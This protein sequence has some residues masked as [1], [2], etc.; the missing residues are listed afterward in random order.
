LL[1]VGFCFDLLDPANVNNLR[2]Y[3]QSFDRTLKESPTSSLSNVRANKKLNCAVFNFAH[4]SLKTHGNPLDTCRAVFVPTMKTDRIWAGSGINAYA[5]I[6]IRV[7]NPECI[8]GTWL[9][10]PMEEEHA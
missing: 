6:Q 2:S 5:H 3:H 8:L 4:E 9:V 10:Q 7:R 1:I